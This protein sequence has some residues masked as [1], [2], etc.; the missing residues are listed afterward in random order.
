MHWSRFMLTWHVDSNVLVNLILRWGRFRRHS[1][2]EEEEGCWWRRWRRRWRIAPGPAHPSPSPTGRH[3]KLVAEIRFRGLMMSLWTV[4]LHHDQGIDY[5]SDLTSSLTLNSACSFS[6][7]P[8]I[9]CGRFHGDESVQNCPVFVFS[10]LL[11][12]WTPPSGTLHLK[13]LWALAPPPHTCPGGVSGASVS[14]SLSLEAWIWSRRNFIFVFLSPDGVC[15]SFLNKIP[16]MTA[17]SSQNWFC[18]SSY[19]HQGALELPL[20]NQWRKSKQLLRITEIK[21]L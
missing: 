18:S 11:S 12:V 6:S 5:R 3:R 7:T 13:T 1:R 16:E 17:D 8:M 4:V 14:S 21:L 19:S 10:S 9:H 20:Q 2:P 15:N